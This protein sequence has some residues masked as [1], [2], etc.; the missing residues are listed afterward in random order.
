MLGWYGY[1]SEMPWDIAQ[2]LLQ[3]NITAAVHFTIL[4]LH[5][6]QERNQGHII[7][8]GSVVGSLPSQGVAVYGAT[9]AFL[10][11][12]STA[13]FRESRNT[14]VHIS[15]VRAGPVRTEF[16]QA[17]AQRPGGF[18]LPTERMGVSPDAVAD[19]VWRLIQHPTRVIYVPRHL[20]FFPWL[21][22]YFGWLIDR[23]GPLLLK[24]A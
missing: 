15:V 7:N 24:R 19:R 22:T 23:L 2:T 10:D 1:G 9:K 21:E 6:M 16:C 14:G 4:T 11:H 3:V 20:M 13:L 12:F 18:N 17:A 8:I 5:D